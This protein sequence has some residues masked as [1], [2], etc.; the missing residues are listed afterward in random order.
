MKDF[1]ME[2][3]CLYA[4]KKDFCLNFQIVFS[5]HHQWL[6]D[7]KRENVLIKGKKRESEREK[8]ASILN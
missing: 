1:I 6:M 8:E 5:N 7:N 3:L 2:M 4:K